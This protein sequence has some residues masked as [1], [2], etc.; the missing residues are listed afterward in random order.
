MMS[1]LPNLYSAERKTTDNEKKKSL[2]PSQ[3]VRIFWQL[4]E[5]GDIE[6][7]AKFMTNSSPLSQDSSI[8]SDRDLEKQP[9]LI[10]DL[11]EKLHKVVSEKIQEDKAEVI[12]EIQRPN[13]QIWKFKHILHKVNDEWKIFS[14]S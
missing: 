14:I 8:S 4:S 12:A 5:K 7:A 11:K 6:N 3:V 10:H 1:S 9:K 2:T 13:K